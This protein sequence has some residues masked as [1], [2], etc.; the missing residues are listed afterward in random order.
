MH[1]GE[2]HDVASDVNEYSGI[3]GRS[4]N[5]HEHIE[6]TIKVGWFIGILLGMGVGGW[7]LAQW[8]LLVTWGVILALMAA[9]LICAGYNRTRRVAGCLIDA[10]KRMSL[11]RFQI[12]CWTL[13]VLSAFITA[14]LYNIQVNVSGQPMLVAIPEAL[15]VV[16]GISTTSLIASPL[17]LTTANE[18][19]DRDNTAA[20]KS[21]KEAEVKPPGAASCN[22]CLTEA[23]WSDLL[24]GETNTN[25]SVLDIARVQMFYF[26]LIAL[27]MYTYLLIDTFMKAGSTAEGY[28]I[29]SL[30]PVSGGL[31][32]L[33]GISHT[34][35]LAKKAIKEPASKPK[36][37]S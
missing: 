7:F 26:T 22:D 1:N 29:D 17:L 10:R 6:P 24:Q 4:M 12:I 27:L 8:N 11:S 21:E 31:I 36:V 23:R 15:W 25:D 2:S 20:N 19:I 28:G 33:L 13:L 32:A 14:V 37:E 35:Y 18:K 16:M 3:V 9:F 5:D 30:P 34:A